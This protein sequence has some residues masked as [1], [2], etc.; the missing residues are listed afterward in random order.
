MKLAELLTEERVLGP[1]PDRDV[2][3]V[4]YVSR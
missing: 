3:G 1:I 2:T 4:Q